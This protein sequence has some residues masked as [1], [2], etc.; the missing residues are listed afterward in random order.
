MERAEEFL[1]DG[2][3]FHLG[4]LVTE[5]SHPRSRQLSQ[6]ARGD[7]ADGLAILFD[8]DR[9]VVETYDRWS[10]SG[11]PEEL[12]DLALA[13]LQGGGRLFFTGC[14]ATGRLSI[15][16]SSIWRTFWQDRRE[17]G[18]SSPPPDTW[19]ARA[20]SVMAGGDYALVKSVE[21]FEDFAPF[22]R[23]QIADLGVSKGDMVFAISE[24]GETS[25][26]IGTAWEGL[27][28]GATVVF[29]YNNP[30]EVLRADVGRSREVLDEPRIRKANLTT[31]PMAITGSTRMQATSIEL[32]ALLTVLEMTLR[33]VV[34]A[35]VEAG[36][37]PSSTVPRRDE[38]GP[39]GAAR[40]AREREPSARSCSPGDGR[41]GGLQEG[42]PDVLLR[43]LPGGG[44][45]HR[46]HGA[47]PDFLHTL[48][49][50]VGRRGGRGVVGVPLH[51]GAH[52]GG[53]LD[54]APPPRP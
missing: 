30:D 41:G 24:G 23:K 12:R 19:E 9:D 8:V 25:F 15:Q 49:P 5:G 28:K 16:L 17:R 18:L 35:G 43:R 22:G 44:R 40:G 3:E 53:S 45:A 38:G 50:A 39:A 21:G 27:E 31:G 1:R 26:V 47:E 36:V 52:H 42:S 48:L 20:S 14:G 51:P 10:R 7:A 2:G 6:V 34:G 11:Q 37:G 33:D 13:T 4:S 46:H 29:V 54:A 32:I